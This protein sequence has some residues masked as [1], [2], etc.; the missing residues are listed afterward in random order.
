MQEKMEKGKIDA[1]SGIWTHE[2]EYTATWVQPLRPA[3]A[4]ML[5]DTTH[6][7]ALYDI[8]FMSFDLK[9]AKV[10]E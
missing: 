1:S 8:D 6:Q 5:L 7:F 2:Y 10:R 3:R 4:W 9:E